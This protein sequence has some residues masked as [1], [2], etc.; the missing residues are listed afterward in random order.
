MDVVVWGRD[1][2][3]S[4]LGLVQDRVG[5]AMKDLALTNREVIVQEVELHEALVGD[6]T[7]RITSV[8]SMNRT[9][10][11]YCDRAVQPRI[12]DK[13]HVLVTVRR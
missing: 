1:P 8:D 13:L 12:G 7:C 10:Y 5:E 6:G 9:Y 2:V 3:R 11:T 4:P